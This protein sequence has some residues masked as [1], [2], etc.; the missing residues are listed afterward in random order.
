MSDP[1][2]MTVLIEPAPDAGEA[3]VLRFAL[4]RSRNVFAW[5]CGGLDEDALR[6]AQ[7]PSAMT[8]GGL[9]KHLAMVEDWT[10]TR[11][12][13]W[14]M[15]EP[16]RSVDWAAEPEYPWTSA[17]ADPPEELYR[18]WSRA[19]ERGRAAMADVIADGGLDRRARFDF[20]P[21]QLP[22][23]RRLLVDLHEEYARHVG[24]LDLFREAIDGLTGEDPPQR[25]GSED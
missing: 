17:A 7:P 23:A 4:D 10:A 14:P 21:N 22:G 9:L 13:G 19:A 11:L 16:W 25:S 2:P 12:T 1:L 18:L 8:I 3:D 6:R 24:H 5:K 20:E 15:P